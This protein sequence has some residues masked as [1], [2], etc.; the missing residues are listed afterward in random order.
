MQE[1]IVEEVVKSTWLDK[2]KKIKIKKKEINIDIT[3]EPIKN[4]E[5]EGYKVIVQKPYET[6]NEEE[7]NKI[8]EI[9]ITNNILHVVFKDKNNKPLFNAI[10]VYDGNRINALLS[11]Q[12][13][14]YVHKYQL[15]YTK[16]I[17][18]KVALIEGPIL[19]TLDALI[20][21]AECVTDLTLLTTIPES[22]QEIIL[23]IYKNTKL[24]INLMFPNPTTLNQMNLIYDLS[25]DSRYVNFCNPKSTFICL[26]PPDKE[27]KVK[28]LGPTIWYKFDL[29]WQ[30]Q[31]VTADFIEAVLM[32]AGY[33]KSILR[34]KIDEFKIDIK[35]VHTKTIS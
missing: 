35:Q 28:S 24:R 17:Y 5:A 9:L 25:G 14:R 3:F 15:T 21:L 22:Y 29:I 8:E 33:T 31:E 1:P 26:I 16:S 23:D 20:P 19:L 30:K 13:F 34:K 11:A 2:F 4:V 32:S 18:T 6:I 12:L 7:W 10:D 27:Y